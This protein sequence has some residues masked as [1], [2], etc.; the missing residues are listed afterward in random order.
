MYAISL[1]LSMLN[2][3][4]SRNINY[5]G[6][7]PID[8]ECNQYIIDSGF[9]ELVRTNIKKSENSRKG[10]QLYMVGK[11]CV[12]SNR[13]GKSVY[14]AMEYV[15]GQK[16]IFPP[17]YGNICEIIANS[18]EHANQQIREKNWLVSVSEESDNTLHFILTDTGQGIL[19]TLKKKTSEKIS[20]LFLKRDSDVLKDVFLKMYQ[21]ITGEINRHKG[22]PMIYESWRDGFISNLQVLTN[23]VLIDF[24]S[25]Q[26]TA[27]KKGFNG[28]LYSWTVS[29]SNYN[30]WKNSL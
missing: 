10:N 17:I 20:D 26:S 25:N 12:D 19:A 5:W 4:S 3:L 15:V 14:E 2:K 27:L 24:E 9:L 29:L 7:Y 6:T 1:M 18:V 30:N 16:T 8:M 21:S 23:K 11:D 13:I 22:L 28:V